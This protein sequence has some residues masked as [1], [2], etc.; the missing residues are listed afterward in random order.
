VPDYKLML[1]C[2]GYIVCTLD[3]CGRLSSFVE[4][5]LT[6]SSTE[7]IDVIWLLVNA[8]LISKTISPIITK[9]NTNQ[10]YEPFDKQLINIIL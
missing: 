5:N 3:R 9:Y 1:T 8:V 10:M 7:F 2:P 4:Y 6:L